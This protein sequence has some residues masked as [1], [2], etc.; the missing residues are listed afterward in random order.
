[1]QILI[2]VVPP[3]ILC[4][5]IPP[6]T[7]P[8]AGVAPPSSFPW[9]DTTSQRSAIRA[10][11]GICERLCCIS[12]YFVF[13][14]ARCILRYEKSLRE[15]IFLGL[16]THKYFSIYI[17]GNSFPDFMPLPLRKIFTGILYFRR[18]GETCTPIPLS[19]V[20]HLRE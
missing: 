9:K 17:T 14:L 16:G 1:M 11:N 6:P 5:P 8:A 7:F 10:L 13:P 19:F 12:I 20:C 18:A 2:E 4:C 15:V 3:Q